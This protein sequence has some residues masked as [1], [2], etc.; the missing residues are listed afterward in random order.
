MPRAPNIYNTSP[1]PVDPAFSIIGQNLATALFGDPE[2][3]AQAQARRAQVERERAAAGYDIERTRGE[4][5]INDARMGW[6]SLGLPGMIA[7][8]NP[9]DFTPEAYNKGMAGLQLLREA[10]VAIPGMDVAPP[11][12]VGSVTGLFG[13]GAP[14]EAAPAVAQPAMTETQARLLGA[15]LGNA[16]TV[17]TAY[18]E[19]Q[20]D[21]YQAADLKNKSDMNDADNRTSIQMNREDNAAVTGRIRLRGAGGGGAPPGPKADKPEKAPKPEK[22]RDVTAPALKAIE[23]RIAALRPDLKSMS[24]AAFNAAVRR[25]TEIFQVTGN[26]IS[27]A[28]RAIDEV[29][30]ETRAPKTFFG[31]RGGQ[32]QYGVRQTPQAD[33]GWGSPVE[34]NR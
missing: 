10:G 18:T 33:T 3:A 24:P 22:A 25:A 30:T 19:K 12:D 31:L 13:P 8:G 6:S 21:D 9:G 16:P 5:D 23:G 28:D 14:S 17:T 27:S 15:I 11:S 2:M 34:D 4:R 29:V 26:P 7:R 32:L 20:G 1:Y